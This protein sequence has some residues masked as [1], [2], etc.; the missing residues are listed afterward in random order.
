MV[1]SSRVLAEL[2]SF[3]TPPMFLSNN[4]QNLQ[5]MPCTLRP[6]GISHRVILLGQNCY[7]LPLICVVF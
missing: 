6:I 2:V 4:A 3:G 1:A 7:E 5:Y